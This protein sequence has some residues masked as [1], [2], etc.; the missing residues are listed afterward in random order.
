MS[1]Q[2]I[3]QYLNPIKNPMPNKQNILKIFLIAVFAIADA[4]SAAVSAFPEAEGGGAESVGGRGGRVIYVTNL[5]DAGP[6]SLRAAVESTGPRIVVFNVSGIIEL[7]SMIQINS[8]NSYLTVAGQTAP[9]GGITIKGLITIARANHVTFRYLTMRSGKSPKYSASQQEF[10]TWGGW[11]RWY[12]K[13]AIYGPGGPK[14]NICRPQYDALLRGAVAIEGGS[15]IML[16]HL[17]M[18]WSNDKSFILWN[19]EDRTTS[20]I[21]L[22]YNLIAEALQPHAAGETIGAATAAGSD[23]AY[24]LSIHHNLLFK[25]FNRVPL[26]LIK[27]AVIANNLIGRA[28]WTRVTMVHGGVQADIIGNIYKLDPP[29]NY[30]SE[31]SPMSRDSAGQG[32]PGKPSI[33]ISGNIG[34]T[35]KDPNGD[36]WVMLG[37]N[38]AATRRMSP[39]SP[40]AYPIT[41]H[42]VNVLENIVLNDVGNSRRLDENGNWIQRRDSVDTRLI[43]EYRTNTGSIAP[44]WHEN[45]VGGWPVIASGTPYADTDRDG[46][47][48]VWETAHGFNPNVADNNGDAD[49]DGYT[50]LEE[51]LN[52]SSSCIPNGG[53]GNGCPAGCTVADDPDCGGPPPSPSPDPSPSPSPDPSPSPS[54]IICGDSVDKKCPDGCTYL[55]DIDCP[56]PPPPLDTNPPTAPQKFKATGSITVP[57]IELTW[58]ASTDDRGVAGY[59]VYRDGIKIATVNRLSYTDTDVVFGATHTYTVS[60]FDL[61]GNESAKS[62]EATAMSAPL[63]AEFTKAGSASDFSRLVGNFL[64]WI[65]TVAGSLAMLIIIIGG[66]MYMSSAGNEQKV[67][68]SKKIILGALGGLI[69]ILMAYSIITLIGGIV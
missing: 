7:K 55:Q 29:S 45:E 1:K 13:G 17:S 27:D 40:P 2:K 47:P 62:N 32:P 25:R 33:Y 19:D 30:P 56:L 68:L 4:A 66:V 21:T 54:P 48:D 14:N 8:A 44:P 16:D 15:N 39:L 65:L 60:A 18:S 46:M 57:A 67:V 9:G 58:R 34:N 26:V 10:N 49:G 12:C 51:F 37:P 6:G 69:L 38:P 61:A 53:P 64:K 63:N 5:D 42:S 41:I 28:L 36:N 31:I 52:G 3:F 22:S 23:K 35:Q 24:G 20:N 50:N 11:D 59:N 43:N